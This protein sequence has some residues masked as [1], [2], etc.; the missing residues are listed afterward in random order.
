MSPIL[1]FRSE[2]PSVAWPGMPSPGAATALALQFQL[3]QT[4]WWPSAVL[5][6]HQMRQLQLLLQHAHDTLPFWRTRLATAGFQPGMMPTREWLSAVPLLKRSEIQAQGEALL[7]RNVPPQHGEIGKGTT[8]GSTGRPINFYTTDLTQY[9]WRGYTLRE[10]VWQQRDL[11]GKLAAIR[12]ALETS[13]APSWGSATDVALE[14]GPC[15]MLNIRT[16]LD[17]QIEWLRSSN[18]D[19]LITYASNLRALALRALARG[20]PLP[21]LRQVRSF[22][23]ALPADLRELCRRAWNVPVVDIYS[24]QEVGYIALQ[25]PLHEHYHVQAEGLIC[26]ILDADNKPC[27]PGQ[28]GRVVV[29]PLHNFAMPLVRYEIGD[30]AE[31]GGPCECGRQLPVI[32][33]ILGRVRNI[34]TLPDGRRHWAS[35]PSE[36]WVHVAPVRQLQLVQKSRDAIL[37][38]IVASRALTL[39]ERQKLGETLRQALGHPFRIDIEEVAEI[40]RAAN[41]KFEEFISEIVD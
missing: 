30:Y 6:Q 33:R 29:T 31:A 13:T 41:Y 20:V 16:D 38:R 7:C 1:K 18:P 22:G 26:E 24:A 5:E 34:L 36:K 35:F 12:T 28:I 10:H 11:S 39:E 2:M 15:V 32:R 23:E 9:F 21:R 25:C 8:S 37:L 4:Q 14:T 17:A 19:Y 40:P 27:A 3:E